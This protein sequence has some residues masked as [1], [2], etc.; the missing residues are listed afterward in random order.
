MKRDN[1][2]HGRT[3]T[4]EYQDNSTSKAE[5]TEERSTSLP[6]PT[7]PPASASTQ[8]IADQIGLPS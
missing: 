8:T 7:P 1:W 3:E 4:R 5:K 2:Q 6:R